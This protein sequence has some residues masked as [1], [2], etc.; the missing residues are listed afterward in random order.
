[1]LQYV[2]SSR[3]P[4]CFVKPVSQK[5][6]QDYF[7]A[8]AEEPASPNRAK[9][10]LSSYAEVRYRMTGGGHCSVC[11]AHVRHVLPV[12]IRRADGSLVEFESLCQR[13]LEGEKALAQSVEITVGSA[14][15][16]VK[17]KKKKTA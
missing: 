4:G 1:M 5:V 6:L 15:W 16:E 7:E 2:Q 12:S 17:R 8:L 13:C 9:Q 11:H 10:V 3:T 14:R